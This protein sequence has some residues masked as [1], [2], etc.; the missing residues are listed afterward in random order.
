MGSWRGVWELVL[1]VR[2]STPGLFTYLTDIKLCDKLQWTT[3]KQDLVIIQD[4]CSLPGL[5]S[6]P[7]EL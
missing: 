4:G 7:R 1:P 3:P 6:S 5:L 2:Q